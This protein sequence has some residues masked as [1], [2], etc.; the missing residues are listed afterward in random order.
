[1]PMCLCVYERVNVFWGN[2]T[3]ESMWSGFMVGRFSSRP[4]HRSTLFIWSRRF[5]FIVTKRKSRKM[6]S[7]VPFHRNGWPGEFFFYRFNLGFVEAISFELTTFQP[8]AIYIWWVYINWHDDN[9][10]VFKLWCM[11]GRLEHSRKEERERE[12]FG[13]TSINGYSLWMP[14]VYQ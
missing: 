2:K 1:M 6:N 5:F 7:K 8:R 12:T 4:Y 10:N 13:M 14:K 9:G 11:E 3:L